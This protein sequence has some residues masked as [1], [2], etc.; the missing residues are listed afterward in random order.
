MQCQHKLSLCSASLGIK[1]VLKQFDA[2]LSSSVTSATLEN[3]ANQLLD[4]T[5]VQL[6][7]YF[8]HVK[9]DHN[10]NDDK[11]KFQIFYQFLCDGDNV[12]CDLT[13]C[14]SARKYIERRHQ[15]SSISMS[16]EDTH[17]KETE[18]P[19]VSAFHILS[20]I[21]T[22]FI[23][24]H[25]VSQL[26]DH[27]YKYIENNFKYIETQFE[28][29]DGYKMA[30]VLRR[31]GIA[32]DGNELQ[33]IF[34]KKQYHMKQLMTDLCDVFT[35][36]TNN[37]TLLSSII[38]EA[39]DTNYTQKEQEICTAILR[40]GF[41]TKSDLTHYN[42]IK[43]LQ[44]SAFKINQKLDP[45][46][47]EQIASNKH[48]TGDIYVKGSS[49]FMTSIKFAKLFKSIK[50]WKKKQ[51]ANI[52]GN[53]QTWTSTPPPTTVTTMKSKPNANDIDQTHNNT[54]IDYIDLGT[55]VHTIKT[56]CALTHA[57]KDTAFLFLQ[58]TS[59]TIALAIETYFKFDGNITGF[60]LY[61]NNTNDEAD[62]DRESKEEHSEDL[63]YNDGVAFWYWVNGK[64]N[65][66]RYITAKC[67][68][69]KDEVFNFTEMSIEIWDDLLQKCQLLEKLDHVKH[70]THNG[71]HSAIYDIHSGDVISLDHLLSIKLY[72]DR[73]EE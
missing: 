56:F 37:D 62:V 64:E 47:I 57:T 17:N 30:S 54:S 1:R 58:E 11:Q 61:E 50:N 3:N 33:V 19:P 40:D 55:D 43:M 12:R 5:N 20:I 31:T 63:I 41:I 14:Q 15:T 18:I 36:K 59:W 28:C 22:Y 73:S 42:F 32:V 2:I 9:Y 49:E 7:N 52:Y 60:Q 46:E 68:N 53:I 66:K 45:D 10:T 8:Y 26:M 39:Q 24:S 16:P 48:L 25:D 4:Y 29:I 71:N 13:Q 27:E 69:L 23:H 38:I 34:D 67:K 65:G 6:M 51:W 70:I 72:S 35:N 21:H 44:I